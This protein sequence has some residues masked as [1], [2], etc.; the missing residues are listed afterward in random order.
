MRSELAAWAASA[1]GRDPALR[2]VA[3][4]ALHATLVFLGAHDAAALGGIARVVVDAARP[5]APIAIGGAAWLPARRP[6]ALACELHDDGGELSSLQ[7]RLATALAPWREPEA[8]PYRPHITVA[9]VRRGARPAHLAIA[10]P[11]RLT[12]DARALVLYSSRLGPDGARYE[13]LAGATL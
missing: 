8:R 13:A 6:R 3:P 9:R 7:A 1:V 10:D 12:F 11:P 2:L 4:D 5:L